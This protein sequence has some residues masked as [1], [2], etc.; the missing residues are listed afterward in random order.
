[1]NTRSELLDMV[2]VILLKN[3]TEQEKVGIRCGLGLN[4]DVQ[5]SQ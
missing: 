2:L 4:S 5:K 1:M 3:K